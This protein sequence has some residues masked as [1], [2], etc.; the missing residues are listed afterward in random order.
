M[1]E[2]IDYSLFV[3]RLADGAARLELAI[4]GGDDLSPAAVERRLTALPGLDDARLN[5]T[6]RRITLGWRAETFRP[7]DAIAALAELGLAAH[8]LRADRGEEA[9]ARH[10]AWLLKCLGVAAFAMM[11]I[12]LLSVSV[13]A[14]NVSDITPET[15][16]FFHWLSALIA[17]PA[18]AYAGQPFFRSALAALSQRTLNMDVPISLGVLLALGVSVYETA[19]HAEHAYFDSAVMLL[20]FLL[21]GRYLDQAMRRRTRAAA[22]NLAALKG[23]IAHRLGADGALVTVPV[24]AIRAGDRVL[25]RPGERIPADGVV[26]AGASAIDDSAITG[27]TQRRAVTID[28]RVHAGG[29]NFDGALTVKAT[30]AAADSL[31]DEIERLVERAG[32]AKSRTLRLVDRVARLYAPVVHVAAFSTALFWVLWGAGPH[33]ALITAIS[34]LII[35]CPCA[36]ALAVP[37]VQVVASGALF[38]S[39][40]LLQ[41]GDAL[42]RLAGVDAIVFDKTGTLTLP[43]PGIANRAEFSPDLVE[44][45]ARLALSSR[46]P[47]AQALAKEARLRRPFEGAVE[48]AGRGVSARIDGVE[49][50]LGAPEFCGVTPSPPGDNGSTIA[51]RIGAASGLMQFRQT[52]RPQAAET[53][54]A[55]AAQGYRLIIL[56][57]DAPEAVAPVARAL[58]VEAWRGGVKPADKI[59]FVEDLR[60]EGR[61]VLMVGDGLNDAPALAAADASLS[62]IAAIDLARAQADAV[63]LGERLTPVAETLRMARLAMK[64][65]RQ[66]LAFSILYNVVAAPLAIA[67]FLTPLIAAAAM[68]GSSMVVTLNALRA[69]AAP[70]DAGEAPALRP[71]AAFAPEGRP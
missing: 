64:L 71:A 5:L 23:E 24:A 42:E 40:V 37:A 12:M 15:R 43:Q 47:L 56:S 26:I 6:R 65:M 3:D 68:S 31:I 45:A 16:D 51:F 44:T 21:A 8:P 19:H 22:G 7:G 69:R 33:F 4:E 2:A 53:V 58:G 62:P 59:A 38:R 32:E 41:A 27:E 48:E 54:R 52:L 57:G 50:R 17:L 28:D 10:A 11:N 35:T 20:F 39:G 13:W 29:L 14:G 66:N 46:H 36:L 18:A 25:V 55:L 1:A 67:G 60:R 49:A 61:K 9:E 30:A 70:R 34:V 63:F